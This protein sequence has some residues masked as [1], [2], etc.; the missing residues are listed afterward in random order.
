MLAVGDSQCPTFCWWMQ[1]VVTGLICTLFQQYKLL[2]LSET[3]SMY[4]A[5][6]DAGWGVG[7]VPG[8]SMVSGL[9]SAIKECGNFLSQD[10]VYVYVNLGVV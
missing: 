3:T 9:L 8:D 1:P 2:D 10:V 4:T 6:V 5:E 7:G